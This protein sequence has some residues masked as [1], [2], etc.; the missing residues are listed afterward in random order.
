MRAVVADVFNQAKAEL[1]EDDGWKEAISEMPTPPPAMEA[2]AVPALLDRRVVELVPLLD[3]R[4]HVYKRGAEV[5]LSRPGN[6]RFEEDFEKSCSSS[7]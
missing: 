4:S 6:E 7:S 5:K 2:P 3:I 1:K